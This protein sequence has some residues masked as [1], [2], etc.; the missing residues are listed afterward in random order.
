MWSLGSK[1]ALTTSQLMKNVGD[2]LI[3]LQVFISSSFSS[4]MEDEK[5]IT[6]P[7]SGILGPTN[8]F[9]ETNASF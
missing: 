5:V 6:L 7:W 1:E 8:T 3:V 9:L 2:S 4:H